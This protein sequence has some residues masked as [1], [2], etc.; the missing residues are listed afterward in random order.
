MRNRFV[1]SIAAAFLTLAACEKDGEKLIVTPPDRPDS[2]SASS[3]EIVLTAADADN[4]AVTFYWKTGA[5]ASVNDP[6]VGIPDGVVNLSLQF[7]KT[8][9]FAVCVSE[10][11]DSKASS[12]QFTVAQ[13]N[14]LMIKLGCTEPV[15]TAVHA[16]LHI[17]VGSDDVFSD[18]LAL[19]VTPYAGERGMKIVNK[20]DQTTTMGILYAKEAT[21]ELYEGFV[22]VPAWYNCFFVA[23][24]GT[25][26]GCNDAWTPYSLEPGTGNNLWFAEAGGCQYVYADTGNRCWSQINLPSVRAVYGA[27]S[28]EL[29]YSTSAGG[30]KGSIEV[31]ADGTAV[32]LAGDGLKFDLTTGDKTAGAAASPFC[33]SAESDG[34]LEFL[35]AAAGG[36][37]LTVEK[38]GRYT[39]V[40]DVLNGSWTL[41]ELN[42]ED[43]QPVFPDEMHAYYYF[44]EASQ[45]L[46]L[47]SV[48]AKTSEDGVYEGFIYTDPAWGNEKSNFRF[49][50]PDDGT[51]YGTSDQFGLDEEGYNMWSG[52]TGLNYI[53]LDMNTMTWSETAVDAVFVAGDFNDWSTESDPMNYDLESGLWKARCNVNEIGWGIQ[54]VLGSDW[55][56]KYGNLSDGK[57]ELLKE[58]KNI[59]PEAA[60]IYDISVNLVNFA[61][62]DFTMEI[63]TNQL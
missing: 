44:K 18:V 61:S 57:L 40:L 20:D 2:F 14:S 15:A 26:W 38:A 17:A 11:L 63:V 60:G 50:N 5:F 31:T 43:P 49:E 13:F 16:R 41:S 58:D 12:A 54:I 22:Y 46:D 51:V 1:L 45:K 32:S 27:T 29:T 39:L 7:S 47:A 28:V 30:F 8:E 52:N 37:S 24:D 9:D 35:D 59:I 36:N 33:L 55:R 42:G 10:S 34:S 6:D 56:W 21:P 48:L 62:P 53:V 4:L 25:A 3:D 19:K 23:P